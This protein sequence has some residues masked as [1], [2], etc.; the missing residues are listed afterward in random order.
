MHWDFIWR[1][2]TWQCPS[3]PSCIGIYIPSRSN[4]Q[5]QS[6]DESYYWL[7]AQVWGSYLI[8]WFIQSHTWAV[9]Q[10]LNRFSPAASHLMW[11]SHLTVFTLTVLVKHLFHPLKK[12]CNHCHVWTSII[13][14][15]RLLITF[16]KCIT[17][18][19]ITVL[20]RKI[21]FFIL[22]TEWSNL[23]FPI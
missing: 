13:A 16:Y 1:L 5:T 3:L 14:E 12:R 11:Q 18:I 23:E 8:K 2:Q 21:I 10:D 6:S 22:Q 17:K 7:T 20:I 19:Q 9:N 4:K 15:T